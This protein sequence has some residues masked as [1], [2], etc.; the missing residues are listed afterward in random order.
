VQASGQQS[1]VTYPS[2]LTR[3]DG[4]EQQAIVRLGGEKAL[5]LVHRQG[6]SEGA[7]SALGLLQDDRGVTVGAVDDQGRLAAQVAYSPYGQILARTVGAGVLALGSTESVF[8]YTGQLLDDDTGLVRMGA[9]DYVPEL[10]SFAT[11]D[12]M[13][14]ARPEHCASS[15]L[16]CQLYSYVGHD[17]INYV[18]E[19]GLS[20]T[21]SQGTSG[22][23]SRKY[24]KEGGKCK[25][26]GA[27]YQKQ[28][29]TRGERPGGLANAFDASDYLASLEKAQQDHWKGKTNTAIDSTNKSKQRLQT[30]LDRING[31]R[32]LDE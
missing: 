18:D 23:Q 2:G 13:V 5:V 20:A 12:P 22:G 11:A 28:G 9:R 15:P 31:L 26:Q 10:A 14:L 8:S 32:D 29:T 4:A 16:E 27:K 1:L 25:K 7:W 30:H 24:K 19:S 21:K 3:D 6:E 17:P